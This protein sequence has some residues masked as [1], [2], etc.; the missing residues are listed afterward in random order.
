[1]TDHSNDERTVICPVEECDATPLARGVYLHVLK[2]TGRGHGQQDEIPD[3]ISLD[4]LETAGAREVKMDYP[5]NR[6]NEKYARLCPYCSATYSGVSGLMIHLGQTAGRKNH[7]TDPKERHEPLDFP[8]V[9]VDENGNIEQVVDSS[10]IPEVDSGKGVVAESRVFR[11][12]ADLIADG[13]ARMA[14]RVR[15]T[16]LATDNSVAPNRREP[17]QPELFEALL[18]Q[19]RA[20]ETDHHI[21]FALEGESVSVACRNESGILS[22]DEA[23]E[24]AR[25]IEQVAA[26]EGWLEKQVRTFISFLREGAEVLDGNKS[27]YELHEGFDFW[28]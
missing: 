16:L 7:P 9:N 21:T 8:R 20:S 11:L 3:D 2:S 24:I 23:R 25:R 18:T 12:I 10:D 28:R 26:A 17:P 19:G 13:K 14:H 4:G 15:R 27:E 1:M 6:D 22:P 5:E